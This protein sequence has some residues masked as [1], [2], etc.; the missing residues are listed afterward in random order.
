MGAIATIIQA[1]KDRRIASIILIAPRIKLFNSIIVRAIIESGKT[2]S[3]AIESTE[4][5]YS[6]EI[7]GKKGKGHRT[8][9]FSKKYLKELR[10]IDIVNYLKQVKIPT[11]IL[12]GTEDDVVPKEEV[13]EACKANKVVRH[14]PINGAGHTFKNSEDKDKLISAVL[15]WYETIM[16]K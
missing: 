1:A 4:T 3:E 15:Q 9:R 8:Y 14:I 5:I 12:R 6:V 13:E 11:L 16:K 2:L 7:K 10:D